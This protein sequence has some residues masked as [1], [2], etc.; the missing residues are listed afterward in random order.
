[1]QAFEPFT[2]LGLL[3][4]YNKFEFQNPYRLRLDDFVNE[5]TI[6][7]IIKSVGHICTTARAMYVAVQEDLPEGWT[8][9]NTLNMIGLGAIAPGAKNAPPVIDPEVA[10]EMF[11]KLYVNETPAMIQLTLL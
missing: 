1:M 6:Q 2:L 3:A 8:L 7:K 5:G 4:N 10:K 9:S 11:A